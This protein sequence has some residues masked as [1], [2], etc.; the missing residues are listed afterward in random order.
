MI[1]K[2]MLIKRKE[3]VY[4]LLLYSLLTLVHAMLVGALLFGVPAFAEGPDPNQEI[5]LKY[6]NGQPDGKMGSVNGGFLIDFVP[7]SEPLYINKISMY[8]GCK[9][10]ENKAFDLEI[11]DKERK[12]I[13]KRTVL[14]SLFPVKNVGGLG[15]TADDGK[16][17][18]I[19]IPEVK[20]S[21]KFY[22]HVWKGP[23]RLT[24]DE[25]HIG[26]DSSIKNI[27]SDISTLKDGNIEIQTISDWNSYFCLCRTGH[28]N[29]K[30]N[31]NWMIRV[32]GKTIVAGKDPEKTIVPSA[33]QSSALQSTAY[34]TP[35]VS[36]PSQ[37]T[38][39]SGGQFPIHIWQ[40][41]T[42][43]A[44]GLIIAGSI[45]FLSFKLALRLLVRRGHMI[46]QDDDVQKK[47]E[48][49]EKE[50]YDL[51]EIKKKWQKVK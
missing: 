30:S 40:I 51:A 43:G 17:V 46:T 42:L 7:T 37:R 27:H 34:L 10:G 16:W 39:E 28:D 19:Q 21:D 36:E 14:N 41:V 20:V 29:N 11:L 44:I 32:L 12:V 5:E 13:Y 38:D 22:V 8:A 35:A 3:K 49:W 24:G 23:L 33:G 25:I 48:E 6:D 1:F 45:A 18:E 15:F 47:L 31:I 9:A 4:R 50:G 2:E 26:I